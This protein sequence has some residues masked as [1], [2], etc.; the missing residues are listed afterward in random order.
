MNEIGLIGLAVMG[1]NLALNIARKG[2]SVSVFN[3]T[4]EK[5]KEFLEERVKNEKIEGYHDIK[6]FVESL[7]KP[8]KIILMVKAGKPVD[9]VI[10]ELLPYLEKG[11]LIIDGGN[12][13]F[14]D[15][16]RR[17][18]ELKE[19][20]I[21]YLGMGVSGGEAG[22]LHGPSLM[23]G[24]SIEAYEMVKDVLLK[25]AAQTESGPCCTYV[26]NDSAGH[27]VK[28]VHNGIE[29]AIMQAI[30]EV[31][32][33]MRK[34]L[35]LSPEEIGDVFERWNNGELNSFLMEISY[36]IMRYKDEET[37]KHLVD[38][39]LDEAE[40]KGTGKWTSQTAL[41]LG[42]PTPSLNLAVEARSLSFFKEDRV[43]L[44]GKVKKTYPDVK[45]DKE[46]VIKDLENALL[47]SVF[48]SFSQ[49]LWLIHEASK[50]FEYNIDL[51]EVLRIWKGGC[52]IR[53]K[54]LDFLREILNENKENVN[55]LDSDKSISFLMDKLDSIRYVTNLAKEFYIPTLVLSSSLDYFLSMVEG[56]L[57]ANL[58]QAQR[59]FFGAHTYRRI[60]KEGIFH[61]EWEPID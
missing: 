37:G 3:R 14:K 7:K 42:I 28:M 29:Y 27:F 53:A 25:I 8:R 23:P 24:G 15:T 54:I 52:I 57:P 38:L 13:Y 48:T 30:A 41:D 45:L 18:K 33:I 4:S 31:Y 17:I 9:D 1:Q 32:D 10:Q 5:T 19:K 12:S 50:T 46:K 60:D 36:K 16:S 34:I 58:I 39:I 59:D 2:Y 56:N 6:S 11:D 51:P 43:K 44:S 35:K 47:F 21:L 22:A 55:L 20:G 26:G 61:T 49:G 40:Q